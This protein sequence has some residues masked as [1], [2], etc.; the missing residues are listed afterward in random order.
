[1][2]QTAGKWDYLIVTASNKQQ[3]VAYKEQLD[4]RR[5][6]GFLSDVKNVVV[7][8]DPDGKRIGSGASTIL[9]F[10]EVLNSELEGS[11]IPVADAQTVGVTR[12][13]CPPMGHAASYSY[14]SPA[15]PAPPF[16]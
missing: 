10:L 6:L 9:C 7:V 11:N 5:R 4:L 12:S 14:P 1:M 8:A 13:D 3:A 16:R 2:P 15:K